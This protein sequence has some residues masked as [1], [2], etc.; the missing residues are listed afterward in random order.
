VLEVEQAHVP[1]SVRAMAIEDA[2]AVAQLCGQLGYQR[3]EAEVREWLL[4]HAGTA[5]RSAAFV[6]CSGDEVLGWIEVSGAHHLQSPSFALIGGLV[7]REGNRNGGLGT[8]LCEQAERWSRAQGLGRIRVT[9][10]STRSDAHR[11]YLRRGYE[12]S[13]TSLVFE[14]RI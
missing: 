5:G 1:I 11:F 3:S 4:E 6:A 7:V 13:K 10:R 2:S 14:K 12:L 9:S 8:L